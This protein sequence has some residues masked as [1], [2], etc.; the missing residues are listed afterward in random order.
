MAPSVKRRLE[1]GSKY[2]PEERNSCYGHALCQMKNANENSN[3]LSKIWP[4]VK[5]RPLGYCSKARPEHC[6][7]RL[8]HITAEA[9]H[10]RH[11]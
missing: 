6:H 3:Y 2:K 9:P 7:N 1:Q 4:S 8:L 10:D 11:F 5:I